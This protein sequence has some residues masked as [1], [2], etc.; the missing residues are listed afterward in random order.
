MLSHSYSV[1]AS[2]HFV[3]S[4]PRVHAY[5]CS[6]PP[7]Q[8]HR[9]RNSVVC[10]AKHVRLLRG[11]NSQDAIAPKLIV[12]PVLSPGQRC[13]AVQAAHGLG[14]HSHCS[15]SE[16]RCWAVRGEGSGAVAAGWASVGV[17]PVYAAHRRR[18]VGGDGRG[19]DSPCFPSCVPC[20]VMLPR[21]PS[22]GGAC[23]LPS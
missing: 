12:W 6:V 11:K 23:F 21:F 15:L 20:G 3:H 22:R 5:T 17:R 2:V 14:S 7:F 13:P 8:A 10:S 16:R 18:V 1:H 9:E 19:P 4:E